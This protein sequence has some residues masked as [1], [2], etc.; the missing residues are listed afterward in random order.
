MGMTAMKQIG[1]LLL[2]LGLGSM[3]LY[4]LQMEFIVLQWIDTWGIEMGWVIRIGMAV[5]GAVL[6]FVA[7]RRQATA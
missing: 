1:G 4:F 5:V 7:S 3:V 2:F 6:L